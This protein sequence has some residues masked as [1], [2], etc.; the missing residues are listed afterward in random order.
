MYSYAIK[1]RSISIFIM[2]ILIT[3]GYLGII[4][5]KDQDDFFCAKAQSCYIQSSELD[6]SNGTRQNV[7]IVG[8][9]DDAEL[10]LQK[11][12]IWIQMYPKQAPSIRRGHGMAYINGTDKLVLFGGADYSKI[13][14]DTWIYDLS[15]NEWLK[16]SPKTIPNVRNGYIMA[17]V[18]GDDKVLIYDGYNDLWVYDL[19]ENN[20]SKKNPINKPPSRPGFGLA[21]LHGTNKIVLFGGGV[22]PNY[23][24]DTWVYD[25]DTN[26]WTN[27]TDP[28]GIPPRGCADHVLSSFDGSDRVLLFGGKD[29]YHYT[30]ET[31]IYT[32][33]SNHWSQKYSGGVPVSRIYHAMTPMFGTE[34]VLLYGGYHKDWDSIHFDYYNDTYIY[35]RTT[36][37]WSKIQPLTSP[38]GRCSHGLTSIYKTNNGVLFGGFDGKKMLNDTWIYDPSAFID[39]GSYISSPVDLGVRSKFIN[40]NWNGT[41]SKN[42]SVQFQIRTGYNI[43]DLKNNSF[44]GPGGNGSTYYNLSSNLL[45]SGHRGDSWFQ[46]KAYLNTKSMYETPTVK[47]ITIIYNKLPEPELLSPK[48]NSIINNNRPLF[49]WNFHDQDSNSQSA[50][51]I[52]IAN[53]IDFNETVYDS[54]HQ[55]STK[56]QWQF[57]TEIHSANLDDGNYYWTLKCRDC[58]GS[59]GYYS[60]PWNFKIDTK[61]PESKVL[62]PAA[63]FITNLSL[64]SGIA[65]DAPGG[66]GLNRVEISIYDQ[67]DD[68]YWDGI[69]W[70]A[71]EKWLVTDGTLQWTYNTTTLKWSTFENNHYIIRSR[72]TDNAT[73][74]E[75]SINDT[76]FSFDIRN[77]ISVIENPLDNSIL[78]S[79]NKISGESF[80]INEYNSGI[81][82]IQICI[83][84]KNN[85]EYWNGSGWAQ[86]KYWVNI[87]EI[88]PKN[89]NNSQILWSYNTERINWVTDTNYS[90]QARSIDRNGNQE[91][92]GFGTN[93]MMDFEPPVNSIKINNNEIYTNTNTVFLTLNAE[94]TGAGVYQMT[95]SN[96]NSTWQAL[97]SYYPF[98]TYEL[99]HGDGVKKVYFKTRDRANNYGRTVSDTIILD[100]T[101]PFGLSIFINNNSKF[102]NS[103]N[104]QV[105]LTGYDSLSGVSSMSF[106]LDNLKWTSWEPFKEIKHLQLHGEDGEKQILLKLRDK[107]GNIAY[108][109]DSIILD[110]TPPILLSVTIDNG[111]FSTTSTNV[112]LKL[113]AFDPISGVFQMSFSSEKY[114]WTKWEKFSELRIYFLAPGDGEKTIFF[115]VLD[116]AGNIAEPVSSSIILVT[117]KEITNTKLDDEHLTNNETK[118]TLNLTLNN[119]NYTFEDNDPINEISNKSEEV[120]ITILIYIIIIIAIISILILI[121]YLIIF[122]R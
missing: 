51:Q 103:T 28:F 78:K 43:S 26:T 108:T 56:G 77:P 42:T 101:P 74:I 118:P 2:L 39:E 12:F 18:Y 44:V 110:T 122:K 64:L 93:F 57:P 67:I 105:K 33:S 97:K 16:K 24:E 94:D 55:E 3:T 109:S 100:S 52:I 48:N 29:K 83:F 98:K 66:S 69:N 61:P 84:D 38:S 20:W 15:D 115:R 90:I 54:G 53:D 17:S 37:W 116:R 60:A 4:L 104:V 121:F 36:N 87:T 30:T 5:I 34:T 85:I 80:D 95:F 111:S 81:E 107:A 76:S 6:F 21:T 114:S 73:N 35:N 91:I 11:V 88:E 50:F 27:K 113:S 89:K 22:Y 49:R 63:D 1:N 13:L 92:P 59:W 62:K 70:V 7:V 40:L 96:D 10:R 117:V 19:S 46:L 99:P 25:V 102:T 72:A 23:F 79:L 112:T 47:N 9:G 82:A 71:P 120:D 41:T 14:T 106:S 8:S 32:L 58:D 86:D 45:W 119:D 75:N 68:S 65:I 31:Y